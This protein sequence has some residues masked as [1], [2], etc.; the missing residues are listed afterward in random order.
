MAKKTK[1]SVSIKEKLQQIVDMDSDIN[2]K[3][4]QANITLRIN[5]SVKAKLKLNASK[6]GLTLNG[7]IRM[8]LTKSIERTKEMDEI[9]ND[10]YQE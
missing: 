5:D 1:N 6:I 7:Y 2:P 4:V 3:K 10:D 9:S 8:I